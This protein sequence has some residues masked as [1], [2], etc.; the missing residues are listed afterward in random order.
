MQLVYDPRCVGLQSSTSFSSTKISARLSPLFLADEE[1][2][3]RPLSQNAGLEDVVRGSIIDLLFLIILA[4]TRAL[5]LKGSVHHPRATGIPGVHCLSFA[6]NQPLLMSM[7]PFCMAKCVVAFVYNVHPCVSNNST[8]L[9]SNG[10][11]MSISS[12]QPDHGRP[13]TLNSQ[14]LFS[15]SF[16]DSSCKTP[17]AL[18]SS[19]NNAI[20]SVLAPINRSRSCP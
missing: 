10:L 19:R 2:R 16:Q 15:S 12:P 14:A 9:S 8:I 18:K 13:F 1:I 20:H 6:Q 4:A 7:I 11:P 3:S 17:W 5:S